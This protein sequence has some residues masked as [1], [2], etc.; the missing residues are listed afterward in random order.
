MQERSADGIIWRTAP[1]GEK[2]LLI[3]FFTQQEGKMRLVAKGAQGEKSKR[4]GTLQS[5]SQLH[6]C[7]IPSRSDTGL[8]RLTRTDF[9]SAPTVDADRYII[10]SCLAE[11]S[12][13]F[14]PLGESVPEIYDLWKEMLHIPVEKPY[15]QCS[16][17]F[18][19]LL[20]VLGVFP[21]FRICVKCGAKFSAEKNIFWL[22]ESG[23]SCCENEY[24]ASEK[25]I[26]SFSFR[27]IKTLF[28][29]QHTA[30]ETFCKLSLPEREQKQL[31]SKIF[32]AISHISHKTFKS[33]SLLEEMLPFFSCTS[34]QPSV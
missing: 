34:P 17:F 33:H 1:L 6:L 10:L 13:Y 12:D 21:E 27:E 31:F 18:V 5:F 8:G 14:I 26:S 22:P 4:K 28:F 25:N 16:G 9:F 19:Q 11:V 15:L 32:I 3:T 29:L 24:T 20:S 23:L 7:Y 2:D 30:L